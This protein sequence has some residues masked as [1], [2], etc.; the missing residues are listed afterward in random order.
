VLDTTL[1][2]ELA[3]ARLG[4]L[5]ASRMAD[6]T[7]R[8][9]TGWGASR[10]NLMAALVCERL[11]GVPMQGHMNEAMR[12]GIEHEPEARAAYEW[13]FDVDVVATGYIP[14]PTIAHSGATPDGAVGEAGL[15]ELKCPQSA[16]HIDTLLTKSIDTKY[17]KQMQW[18]LACSEREWVDF[19]TFDPRMPE[20]LRLWTFRVV[21]DDDMISV[22]E[23]DARQFLRELDEKVEALR[24]IGRMELAA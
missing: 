10:A 6:A 13:A 9:K 12:W 23:S 7:A 21:R 22:L 4:N 3:G 24:K 16:T 14:H 8:T 5:T 17:I 1:S 18:Q 11:T 2:P 15:I 20:P 19:S